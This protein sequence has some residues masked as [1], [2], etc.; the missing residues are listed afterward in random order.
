GTNG[1]V[2]RRELGAVARLDRET[3]LAA[4]DSAVRAYD[5]GRGRGP[6]MRLAD[7]IDC[8]L[9][10]CDL[11]RQKREEAVRL[12]M[13]EIG[14]T[15]AASEKEFDRTLQYALATVEE[16]K[17]ADRTAGRFMRNSGILAQ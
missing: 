12:L 16:L 6:T 7:R 15:R 11:M 10:F 8:L 5:G 17:E 4:L 3:A 1:R 9:R 2:A 13:W 14:K